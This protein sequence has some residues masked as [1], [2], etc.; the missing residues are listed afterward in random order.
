MPVAKVSENI[1]EEQAERREYVKNIGIEYRYGCYEEKRAESCHI[2]GDYMEAIEQSFSKAYQLYK[3][4][5]E[6]RKFPKSCYKL[7]LYTLVGKECEP[8]LKKMIEPLKIACDAK[9]PPA[10][11]YLSLVYWNGEPD[12]EPDSNKAE[13][14]MK[15]ACELEDSEACWLLSTWYINSDNFKVVKKGVRKDIN[16]N[17]DRL[18][19][20]EKDM[21]KALKYAELACDLNIPQSCVNAARIL[22]IGDG[23]PK[24]LDK[25]KLL[26]DKAKAIAESMKKGDLTSDYTG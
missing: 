24:D 14:Y 9:V 12:R 19:R 21:T 2:L 7:A 25:A 5:C 11:R 4:N 3:D 17:R 22:K 18:G 8:S 13:E 10:C 23:V 26:L 6:E 1:E 16:I 20:L 15:R